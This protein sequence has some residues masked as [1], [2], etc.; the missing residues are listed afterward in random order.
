[1]YNKELVKVAEEIAYSLEEMEYLRETKD[2]KWRFVITI[3]DTMGEAVKI[4]YIDFEGDM[5]RAFKEL[6]DYL[7]K[8]SDDTLF[9]VF[10]NNYI[11]GAMSNILEEVRIGKLHRFGNWV[12]ITARKGGVIDIFDEWEYLICFAPDWNGNEGYRFGKTEKGFE[13]A[14]QKDGIDTEIIR[15][16]P[17]KYLANL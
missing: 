17:R 16:R 15:I 12:G 14:L 13:L 5:A 4:A 7:N 10:Y 1:M 6:S 11:E 9:W 8:Y 3:E 2:N